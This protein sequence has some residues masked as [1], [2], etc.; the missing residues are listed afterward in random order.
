MKPTTV[1][2][3]YRILAIAGAALGVILAVVLARLQ[4]ADRGKTGADEPLT[5]ETSVYTTTVSAIRGEILDRSGT[6]LITNEQVYSIRFNRS[7]WNSVR[8]NQ[9]ILDLINLLKSNNVPH[10]DSL[11]ISNAPY[12]FTISY[13]STL[14]AR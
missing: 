1:L 2:T 4:L 9:V 5:V 8:Q 10:N 11:P 12:T 3:R 7:I 6:P 13:G 14:S